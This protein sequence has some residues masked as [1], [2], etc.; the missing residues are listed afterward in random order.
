MH[1][2]L[3]YTSHKNKYYCLVVNISRFIQLNCIPW[4]L[5]TP[6][7]QLCL[8]SLSNSTRRKRNLW[9]LLI[10][11]VLAIRLATKYDALSTI[12][13]VDVVTFRNCFCPSSKRFSFKKIQRLILQCRVLGLCVL[14]CSFCFIALFDSLSPHIMQRELGASQSLNQSINCKYNSWGLIY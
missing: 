12:T 9:N 6:L 11:L 3:K 1:V 5:I 14:G 4:G 7:Q 13:F 2:L 8:H 10:S